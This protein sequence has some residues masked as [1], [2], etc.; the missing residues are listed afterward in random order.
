MALSGR[1]RCGLISVARATIFKSVGVMIGLV[2]QKAA[3]GGDSSGRSV[4]AGGPDPFHHSFVAHLAEDGYDMR[5]P[6]CIT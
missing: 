3:A 2:T 6:G 4:Q 1:L 5:M